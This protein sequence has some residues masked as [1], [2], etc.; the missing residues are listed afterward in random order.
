MRVLVT[1]ASGFAGSSVACSLAAAGHVVT[2]LSRTPSRFEATLK[3]VA[4]LHLLQAPLHD[5]DRLPGPFDAIVHAAATSPGPGITVD[6]IVEDTLGGTSSLLAAT[7]R[8][9]PR[10]FVFYSSMSVYGT[11]TTPIVDETTPIVDP[12]AYGACKYLC[13]RLLADRAAWLPSIAL[14]LPGVLGPGARRNWLSGVADRLAAGDSVR[15]FHLAAPF[16]N[17]V[18]VADLSQFVL[19]L[20][21][22]TWEGYDAVVL[23]AG[24]AIEVEA[25]IRRLADGLGVMAR[26]ETSPAAKPSFILS[27][28]RAVRHWGY[29]PADLGG[30]LDRYAAD[31]LA[32]R[33][34]G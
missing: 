21:D 5:A 17:A 2:A 3:D 27:S 15:A 7:D 30:L 6:R 33:A 25:V 4:G 9:R 22:R 16:N 8:W 19:R 34:A 1:G 24:A 26:I 14:R 23:G 20:I 12:D 31:V 28:D 13:E 32:W 10:A 11:I 18:H 29:E